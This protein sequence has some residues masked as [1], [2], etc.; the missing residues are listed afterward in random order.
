MLVI[1]KVV[2]LI[3]RIIKENQRD[4]IQV[5]ITEKNQDKI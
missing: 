2:E 3:P 1:V 5:E 4:K